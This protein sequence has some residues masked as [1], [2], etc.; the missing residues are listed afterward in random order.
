MAEAQRTAMQ[1]RAR[2]QHTAAHNNNKNNEP[3]KLVSA[4]TARTH[5]PHRHH[6]CCVYYA[7]VWS[8]SVIRRPCL[9]FYFITRAYHFL[10][11]H[12]LRCIVGALPGHQNTRA[13][14]FVALNAVNQK[15]GGNELLVRALEIW[16]RLKGDQNKMRF[17]F[18]AEGFSSS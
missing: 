15:S 3:L 17:K 10:Y 11:A 9:F 2:T 18:W 7:S 12:L 8:L 14:L 16:I 4:S 13:A 5:V 6:A 1:L